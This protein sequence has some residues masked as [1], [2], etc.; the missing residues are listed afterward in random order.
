MQEDTLTV[1]SC[2]HTHGKLIFTWRLGEWSKTCRYCERLAAA[3]L[4]KLA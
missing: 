1:H 3:N 2:Y 4:A